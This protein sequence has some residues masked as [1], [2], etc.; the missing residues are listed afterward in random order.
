MWSGLDVDI[1]GSMY[2]GVCVVL[3]RCYLFIMIKDY[4][5]D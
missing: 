4:R 1:T 3:N 2:A 5:V